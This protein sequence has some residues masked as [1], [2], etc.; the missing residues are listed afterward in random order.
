VNRTNTESGP[1]TAPQGEPRMNEDQQQAL[2]SF[3]DDEIEQMV[4]RVASMLAA[5]APASKPVAGG[6]LSALADAADARRQAARERRE[7]AMEIVIGA[8][9]NEGNPGWDPRDPATCRATSE[10]RVLQALK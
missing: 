8:L 2:K 1:Q 3:V 9:L 10:G 5:D 7:L 6:D 4:S